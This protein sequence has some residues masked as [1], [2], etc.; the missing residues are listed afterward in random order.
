VELDIEVRVLDPVRMVKP[1][2]HGDQP[3]AKERDQGQPGL[4]D[5]GEVI[6]GQLRLKPL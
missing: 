5:P 2:R 1:E 6:K 4:N 3:T